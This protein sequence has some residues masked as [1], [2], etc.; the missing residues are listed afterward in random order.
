[1]GVT[2]NEEVADSE[3]VADNEEVAGNEEIADN[4][5]VWDD[6]SDEKVDVVGG[7]VEEGGV[8]KVEGRVGVTFVEVGD[9]LSVF[10]GVGP[11]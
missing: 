2:D 5:E 8:V 3:E 7:K 6:E 1:M 9:G 11:P 4:E 10:G